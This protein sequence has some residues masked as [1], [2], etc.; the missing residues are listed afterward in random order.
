MEIYKLKNNF[1]IVYIL[2]LYLQLFTL[3][4]A[5]VYCKTTININNCTGYKF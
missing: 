2:S 1:K 4:H 3:L 5:T